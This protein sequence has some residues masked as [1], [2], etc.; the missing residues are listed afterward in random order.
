[1]RPAA[2]KKKVLLFLRTMP[3]IILHCSYCF[4]SQVWEARKEE[5]LRDDTK[6][7]EERDENEAQQLPR[8]CG[9]QA[10]TAQPRTPPAEVKKRPCGLKRGPRL[11]LL[12]PKAKAKELKRRQELHRSSSIDWHKK[13]VKKGVPK[14]TKEQTQKARQWTDKIH[15]VA[16]PAC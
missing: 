1:M 14:S 9:A 3:D 6:E 5:P 16:I 8:A 11:K 10:D 15:S 2:V 12:S 13:W 4:R 7:S